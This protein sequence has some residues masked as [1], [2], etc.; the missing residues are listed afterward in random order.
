M[1]IYMEYDRVILEDSKGSGFFRQA[2]GGDGG[3]VAL[4]A[5]PLRQR[6]LW[7]QWHRRSLL[8]CMHA[9]A[10]HDGAKRLASPS[11]CNAM[12]CNLAGVGAARS[13]VHLQSS[14]RPPLL[15][16]NITP[17]HGHGVK[18]CSSS[19]VPWLSIHSFTSPPTTHPCIHIALA[20][21]GASWLAGASC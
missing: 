13:T 20:C 3:A 7:W 18:Y 15:H 1:P 2:V 8:S 5:W 19:V 4:A 11:Q 6:T 10:P 21:N 9:P 16:K 12:Q 14:P 17:M